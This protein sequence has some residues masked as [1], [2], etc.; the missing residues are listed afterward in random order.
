M[1]AVP[2]PAKALVTGANGY[3]AVWVVRKLLE[4]GYSVVGTV[5]SAAKGEH[6]T[7]L[8]AEYGAKFEVAVVPD[9]TAVSKFISKRCILG[10]LTFLQDGAFDEVV[11]GVELVEHT[12]SPFHLHAKTAAE[13]IDPAV[14]GT[15]GILN[16]IK[17]NGCAFQSP[18]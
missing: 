10:D 12:A 16:S 13:L 6:L 3:I 9:I 8:F 11:K 18:L 1:P 17:K 7:K 4:D 14:R 5:R 15:T 2:A